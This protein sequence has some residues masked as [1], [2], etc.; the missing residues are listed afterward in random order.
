VNEYQVPCNLISSAQ[1]DPGSK[2]AL[3]LEIKED[4]KLAPMALWLLL[5]ASGGPSLRCSRVLAVG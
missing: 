5:L 1:A 3:V 2:L 4:S